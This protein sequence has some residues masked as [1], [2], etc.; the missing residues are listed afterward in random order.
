M[1]EIYQRIQQDPRFHELQAKRSLFSWAL[2]IVVL[3][4]YFAFMVHSH[5]QHHYMYR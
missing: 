4:A 5:F 3:A 1:Q 2:T